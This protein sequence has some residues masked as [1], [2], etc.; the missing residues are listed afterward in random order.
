[1]LLS[2]MELP[3]IWQDWVM[4]IGQ[5]VF[6]LALLPS[7]VGKDKPNVWT[8]FITASVSTIY[9][10]TLWSLSL[11]WGAIM[12]ALLSVTWLILAVQKIKQIHKEKN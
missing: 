5:L 11:F 3:A 6:L 4:A 12:S 10:F 8:S 2:N 1:M 7:I 9:I